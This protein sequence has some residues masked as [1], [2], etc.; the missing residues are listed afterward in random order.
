VGEPAQ[1]WVAAALLV[2]QDEHEA[3]DRGLDAELFWGD[4]LGG[5]QDLRRFGGP[6]PLAIAAGYINTQVPLSFGW[7][8]SRTRFQGSGR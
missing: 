2:Q 3:A 6:A 5:Q 4:L 7:R 8:D 1:P